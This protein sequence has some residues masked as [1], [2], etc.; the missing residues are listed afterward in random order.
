METSYLAN[1]DGS[2]PLFLK[3]FHGGM[4][5]LFAGGLVQLADGGLW[6]LAD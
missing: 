6:Q 3:V 4:D 2:S 5:N 1:E